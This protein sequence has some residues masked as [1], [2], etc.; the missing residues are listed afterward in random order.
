[1]SRDIAESDW[2]VFKKLHAIALERFFEKA[3]HEMRAHL[4]VDGT[5]AKEKFW[6]FFDFA[7]KRRK[8]AA[9]LFDDYRRSTAILIM[10]LIARHKLVTEHELAEFSPEALQQIQG[11]LNF[12]SDK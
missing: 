11:I 3:M 5:P 8:L 9:E 4:D 7:A 6:E 12:S 2:K 10:G 1:M